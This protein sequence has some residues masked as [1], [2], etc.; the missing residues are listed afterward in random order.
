MS[1]GKAGPRAV[2][3]GMPGAGK[4]RVGRM[5]AGILDMP[6]KDADQEVERVAG[7]SIAE[8]METDGEPAFR[9]V[10]QEVVC[11]LLKGFN[12]GLFALGGGSP[13]T[14]EVYEGLMA[15]RGRGG[16]IIYLDADPDEAAA[17]AAHGSKRPLLARDAIGRWKRLY[18]E[19]RPIYESLAT[20]SLPSYGSSPKAMAG[21]LAEA[22]NERL[23]HITGSDPYDVRIGPGVS[24]RLRTLLGEQVLRVAL[25]HTRPVQRHADHARALLRQ[26]GYRVSDITI[27]DAEAGKTVQV[28]DGV[29]NRL[30]EDGFTRSDAVVGL[31][32]G[33]ATD[34]AGFVAASWM[35][36]IPYVNCPTSLL[37][38]VD[39][40]A[41][42]KTGVNTP[43]GKNLVGAFY[44][45][46]GVLADLKTLRTLP[47]EI[48]VEG[49]GEVVKC[50]FIMD[51]SILDLLWA[52]RD[53][54]R[55]FTGRE[56]DEWI[57]EV[58]GELVERSV[59]VKAGYVSL[60]LRESGPREFLNYGHTLGHAIEQVEHFSWRHGQAVAVGMVF[61]AELSSILG[62]AERDLVVEHRELVEALGLR[63]SWSGGSWERV[64]DLMHRDK[65]ARGDKLRFIILD[66]RG[67][68]THLDD[69]P[70]DAVREAFERIRK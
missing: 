66:G 51:Q 29:W 46:R 21:R 69:P 36:G 25:I 33:A 34:L 54:L 64:L 32:G 7:R 27:P 56:S 53:E 17:R 14:T 59:T 67:H 57:E 18:E 15:Y 1:A 49:L 13:M 47:R 63:T 61:A 41:G 8:I 28:A 58:P 23:V 5:A 10:E 3:I 55:G 40:S 16:V 42:G 19:R 26:G 30:A 11:R 48:F 31:G 52:H 60:D 24:S 12:G 6:F 50:G 68:P 45:P 22:L 39:A 65:K 9:R 20:I 37:A 2:I 38:M 62:Y 70:E 35:R 43:Q 44:T 4:T